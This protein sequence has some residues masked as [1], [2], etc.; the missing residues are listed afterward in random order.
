[1]KVFHK[2]A[3]IEDMHE[4]AIEDGVY[5]IRDY[6]EGQALKNLHDQVLSEI[7]RKG[8]QNPFGRNLRG[9]SLSQYKKESAIYETF[10]APWMK[11]L[12]LRLTNGKSKGYGLSVYA[13]HDYIISDEL[14]RFGWLHFDRTPSWKYFIYLNDID[15][16]SGAFSIVQK[17]HL[18]GSQLFQQAWSENRNYENVKNRI[19]LDYPDIYEEVDVVPIEAP[20]GTLIAFDTNCFHRGG[21]ILEEGK[22]RIVVRLNS[23]K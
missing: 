6:I 2:A 1:M 7:K 17:S 11:E 10:S 23:Y 21:L 4:A 9:P 20:A 22:E 18:L 19:E 8:G 3:S 15:E 16:S 5:V 13:N 12:Y 14:A